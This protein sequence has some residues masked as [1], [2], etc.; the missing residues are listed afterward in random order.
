[1]VL[2]TH[3]LVSST[4]KHLFIIDPLSKLNLSFDT[5][6]KL[7]FALSKD[8]QDQIFF[9]QPNQLIFCGHDKPSRCRVQQVN[10]ANQHSELKLHEPE[11]LPLNAFD[12]VHMRLEPPYDQA[13]LETL[14]IL[15]AN[16][17]YTSILNRPKAL[18]SFNEK[19][20]ISKFPNHARRMC[21]SSDPK[22]LYDFA[23]AQGSC[24]VIIKPLNLYGGRG[25]VRLSNPSTLLADLTRETENSHSPRLCQDYIKAVESGEVRAFTAGG[26]VTGWCLK[27]PKSGDFLAN[28][29]AGSTLH[30]FTPDPALDAMVTEVSK[31]LLDLGIFL[32]GFDIIDGKL[33]EINITCPALLNPDRTGL[34][35]ILETAHAVRSVKAI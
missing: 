2:F 31:K 12:Q 22:T 9:A 7:S 25:V 17:P 24:D 23:L 27:V 26:Q 10:F 8:F 3:F 32:A 29:R 33:S 35:G 15:E 5:T 30:R 14:W 6:I 28:T 16:T 34:H 20:I 13:Y 18:L 4:L 11:V 21:V 19:M 1:L